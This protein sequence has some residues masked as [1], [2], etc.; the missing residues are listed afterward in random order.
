MYYPITIQNNIILACCLIYNFITLE[1]DIDPIE[2]LLDVE[3]LEL[4]H[5]DEIDIIDNVESTPEW[6]KCNTMKFK[7]D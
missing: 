4:H 1:M 5:E 6:S 7:K 3:N 2:H